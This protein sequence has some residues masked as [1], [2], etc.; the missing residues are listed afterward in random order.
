M[1]MKIHVVKLLDAQKNSEIEILNQKKKIR[2][3]VPGKSKSTC[4]AL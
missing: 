2:A 1:P 3:P 4:L